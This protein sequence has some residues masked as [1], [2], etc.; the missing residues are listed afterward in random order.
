MF[1]PKSFIPLY[2]SEIFGG[3]SPPYLYIPLKFSLTLLLEIFFLLLPLGEMVTSKVWG[4]NIGDL[5]GFIIIVGHKK[6]AGL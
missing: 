4:K 6:L 1:Y 5:K 3:I 2:L